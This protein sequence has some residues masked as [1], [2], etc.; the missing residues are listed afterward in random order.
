MAQVQYP[1]DELSLETDTVSTVRTR[2]ALEDR[3]VLIRKLIAK[4]PTLS[5]KARFLKEYDTLCALSSPGIL[6]TLDV[7]EENDGMRL[8]LEDFA[9]QQLRA[10]LKGK[11]FDIPEFLS[12][13]IKLAES[14]EYL[15]AHGLIHGNINP[16]SILIDAGQTTVKLTDFGIDALITGSR[17]TLYM[18]DFIMNTLPYLAPEQTGRVNRSEDYRSDFYSL[19]ITLFEMLTGIVPFRSRDPLELIH[20]HIARPPVRPDV[21]VP[22]LPPALGD[23]LIKLMAKAPEERYQSAS[24]LKADLMECQ[25]RLTI[26]GDSGSFVIGKQDISHR[27]II[28]QKLY[29][30]EKE[31]KTL[32]NSFENVCR[33]KNELML[34]SGVSGIGKSALIYEIHKPITAMQGYFISG[35]YE[36]YKTD[37]PYSAII[38]AFKGLLRH[39]LTEN[40]AA[41]KVWEKSF[42]EALG[43]NAG[44]MT[45][46]LPELELIIGKQ[47]QPLQL[48]PEDASNRFNRCFESFVN[49]FVSSK[50]P[51]VLFLDD[52]QWADFSSLNLLGVLLLSLDIRRMYVIFSYRSDEVKDT[53]PFIE[54]VRD[55][56]DQGIRSRTLC[57]GPLSAEDIGRL[58]AD[59]L[60][61][62]PA[63]GLE[64]GN[65]IYKKTA[66]NPF[67][68]NQFL[69]TLYD[70][71]KIVFDPQA[72]W[73]WNDEEIASMQVTDN[74]VTLMAEKIEK[75]PPKT[76]EILI[77]SSC[78]GNRFDLET[79]SHV[80]EKSLFDIL[81]DMR[82]AIEE[83]YVRHVGDLFLYHHDRIQ[84]AA[85]SLIPESERAKYHLRI[86][87]LLLEKVDATQN[88]GD[89]LFY[90][91]DQL[92][93]CSA[94]IV[95]RSEQ[96]R[97]FHLNMDAGKKAKGTAAFNPALNYFRCAEKQL[98]RGLG[99]TNQSDAL[100]VYQEI[101]D[102]ACLIGNYD[103]MDDY[104]QKV[105][106]SS[107]SLAQRV[108]ICGIEIRAHFARQDYKTAIDK[109][110]EFLSQ[111]G[112]TFPEKVKKFHIIRE[113][114]TVKRHLRSLNADTLLKLPP[115]E[116]ERQLAI[117]K[118]Y[119]EM[120]ICANLTDSLL[121]GFVVL[122]RFTQT[123]VHGLNP[124][125]SLCF[126]GY[127]AFLSSALGDIEGAITFG[128]LALKLAER[129]EGQALKH[130][131][132]TLYEALI[133]HLKEPIEPC[134]AGAIQAY[135]LSRESGDPLYTAL[136]LV[137]RDYLTSLSSYNITEV[138]DRLEQQIKITRKSG[139][140]PLI[141]LHSMSLQMMHH[142]THENPDLLKL[143]GEFFDED[144]VIP[145][146]ME[147]RNLTGLAYYNAYKIGILYQ[148]DRLEEAFQAL[149]EVAVY[150]K[151]IQSHKTDQ[152]LTYF[153][154]LVGLGRYPGLST[155]GKLKTLIS[156][157]RTLKCIRR[158]ARLEPVMNTPWIQLIEAEHA[159]IKG[160][161][162]KAAL[163]YDQAI[164]GFSRATTPL[165]QLVALTRAGHYY[166][167]RGLGRSALMYRSEALALLN[168]TG[169]ILLKSYFQ[170]QWA[171]NRRTGED[172]LAANRRESNSPTSG[173]GLDLLTIMKSAQ[174]LSGEIVL[175]KLLKT[176]MTLSV[177][178]AGA[179]KGFLI[180]EDR[181]ELVIKAEYAV[182]TNEVS[183]HRSFPVETCGQL[184]HAVINFVSR[185]HEAV[186]LGQ[187]FLEGEFVDDAYIAANN[188]KSLLAAPM[189]SSGK[190]KGVIYLENNLA[191]HVFSPERIQVLDVLASQAAISLENAQLFD[192]VKTTENKL[193]QFNIE[194]EK[195][196]EERTSELKTA[197]NQI[198]ILANTDPLTGLSNR[199]SMMDKIKLELVRFKRSGKPFALVIADIDHFKSI[200]D[201]FGH[202]CGDHV[203]V[204]LAKIMV[205]ALREEDG[206]ARWG[207]EEFLFL[208]PETGADGALTAMEKIRMIICENTFQF[209]NISLNLSMTFGISV[210]DGKGTDME[211]YLKQ[212]DN[213]L[214]LG[215][216]SGRN[217]VV[218]GV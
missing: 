40:E 47:P 139:Q 107:P 117:A 98:L 197:Y 24:G 114:I 87:R 148:M 64:L 198:Q 55:V 74:V 31:L 88:W 208:L 110:L 172:S 86:G 146:W 38:Q 43:A 46:I 189:I 77:I 83:G 187:A 183:I 166:H 193:R 162:K 89:Q 25:R 211:G 22:D 11:R 1:M 14:L 156:V 133:H 130:K 41:I 169:M 79:L 85:Y 184:S 71:G 5:E 20:C 19:G 70:N 214:Y 116:D 18:H 204:T 185:S 100:V 140:R 160:D 180:L 202:D 118:M 138:R 188:I 199:R 127:G 173:E 108:G 58:I 53:H 205:D 195:R 121:Y 52:L 78:M 67:F 105:L 33:G 154:C 61:C 213:A 3:P 137:Y 179:Q 36:Q 125:S 191:F 186:V 73:Q 120:G 21:F 153:Q 164:E 115:M 39:I 37:S 2:R 181:N 35:K 196:V 72:G 174:A 109:S 218:L 62:S 34:I 30:R 50:R 201:R 147:T 17:S 149:K 135:R 27:F 210:Y 165:P 152:L 45:E 136:A 168:S 59:F 93:Q 145:E 192:T 10:V 49:V 84:E 203:L 8:V 101:A 112:V 23:I 144:K 128:D 143:K 212:A 26:T 69:K 91:T 92:N 123:L 48:G 200:N 150:K 215:K 42:I 97:L 90:I 66:G 207:G 171:A 155:V 176:I 167:E 170:N 60:K 56:E 103:L 104:V 124:Y 177:E 76:K 28:P 32:L 161:D 163:C 57:L 132:H 68:V 9:G 142:F 94:L 216:N 119:F 82:T 217:R 65:R 151:A 141:Q 6:C 175:E 63:K 194:L 111:Q 158:W 182:D 95:E 206:V 102:A 159:A 122:K 96:D 4:N 190:L 99:D 51:L 54:M 209:T 129:P 134:K 75:L 12:L 15:H 16:D 131:I 126:L 178:S 13:G 106:G 81:T 113:L 7:I 80:L 29:G 44:V 157:N